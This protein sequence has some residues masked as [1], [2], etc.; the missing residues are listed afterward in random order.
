M[1][2]DQTYVSSGEIC[3]YCT[4]QRFLPEGDGVCVCVWGGG[5][6]GGGRRGWMRSGGWRDYPEEYDLFEN[7][8][9]NSLLRSQKFGSKV[10]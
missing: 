10:R 5:G 1:M 2:Y 3:T 6:G 9:L 4:Y 7:W 8:L